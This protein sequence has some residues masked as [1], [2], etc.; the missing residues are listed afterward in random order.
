[1]LAWSLCFVRYQLEPSMMRCNNIQRTLL[2]HHWKKSCVIFKGID[3]ITSA[4]AQNTSQH[5]HKQIWNAL[6]MLHWSWLPFIIITASCR[7][8]LTG[9]VARS[10]TPPIAATFFMVTLRDKMGALFVFTFALHV[11]CIYPGVWWDCSSLVVQW[12][13]KVL[14]WII[15]EHIAAFLCSFFCIINWSA[16]PAVSLYDSP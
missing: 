2:S 1:M 15:T 14:F 7:W 16:L 8:A 9:N 10:K 12:L 5:L 11:S 6:L 13:F 4:G 3:S